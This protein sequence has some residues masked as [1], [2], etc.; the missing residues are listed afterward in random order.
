VAGQVPQWLSG[1]IGHGLASHW[2]GYQYF[3]KFLKVVFFNNVL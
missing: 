2:Y 3:L 1:I